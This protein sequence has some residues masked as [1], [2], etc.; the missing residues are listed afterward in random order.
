PP[1]APPPPPGPPHTHTPRLDSHINQRIS[2]LCSQIGVTKA[3]F[4]L[5]CLRFCLYRRSGGKDF[6]IGMPHA[7]RDSQDVTGLIG[8][9]VGTLVLQL[10]NPEDLPDESVANWLT[11]C[12]TKLHEVIANEEVSV[13]E[14]LAAVSPER[15]LDRSPLFQV[16]L[17]Y[18]PETMESFQLGDAC[19]R[20]LLPV[21]DQAK[22][23]WTVSVNEAQDGSANIA[24]EYAT[25][26]FEQATAE[27]VIEQLTGIAEAFA[28]SAEGPLARI[29][30]TPTRS[31]SCQ[32]FRAPPNR[33]KLMTSF[34]TPAFRPKS[35]GE[36]LDQQIREN[37]KQIAIE[38]GE[39]TWAYAELHQQTA[40]DIAEGLV[41]LSPDRSIESLIGCVA[42]L[43]HG[44]PFTFSHETLEADALPAEAACVLMTSGTTGQSK[45]VVISQDSLHRHSDAFANLM[46]LGPDDRVAQYASPEFDLFLEEVLPTLRSGATLCVVPEDCRLDPRRFARWLVDASISLADL[47]TAFFHRWME[48]LD[49]RKTLALPNL[50]RV[51]VGGE[52]LRLDAARKWL[53]CYPEIELWNTYGPT[54]ATIICSAHRVV[55]SD[56]SMDIPL[57]QSF[58]GAELFV[59]D[60]DGY[61][62]PDGVPG[63]LVIAGPGVALGYWTE[64]KL[65]RSGGF[66]SNH[67]FRTG[68]RVRRG[69]DGQLHF[70]GRVDEQVKI[71]GVRVSPSDVSRRIATHPSV[72]AASVVVDQR[73]PNP[74]L[75]A[76]LVLIDDAL[77]HSVWTEISSSLPPSMRP[78]RWVRCDRI[79]LTDRGKTDHAAIIALA[80]SAHPSE[81]ADNGATDW[82]GPVETTLA[83][84]WSN[85]LE[86][87]QFGRDDDFFLVGGHS[88][89]AALLS[90]EI[91]QAFEVELTLPQIFRRPTIA[92]LATLIHDACVSTT[93]NDGCSRQFPSHSPTPES[94][95][96]VLPGLPG[97]GELYGPLNDVLRQQSH[98]VSLSIPGL[99]E[100]AVPQSIPALAALWSTELTKRGRG[101]FTRPRTPAEQKPPVP[102]L[103]VDVVAHSFSASVLVEML[104]A[105]PEWASRCRRIVLLDAM[106]FDPQWLNRE[107]N[108]TQLDQQL[109]EKLSPLLSSPLSDAGPPLPFSVEVV[110]AD[111][112][113]EWMQPLAW[114]PHFQHVTVTH[115]EGDHRS[116]T[117]P[118][119]CLAWLEHSPP[120]Q[121]PA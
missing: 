60:A 64:G 113:R 67:S 38:S 13:D 83:Q 3:A 23:E 63:E 74:S 89:L 78:N 108:K 21:I 114:K 30:L 93:D 88:L 106:P 40:A 18:A 54:E 77:P 16:L 92:G 9:F 80:D 41:H 73:T 32:D 53:H 100:G 82:A 15:R 65:E 86:H 43:R 22:F 70:L 26:L 116:I 66:G 8:L 81:G 85:L 35:F 25:D 12:H 104:R 68:D 34:A 62:L 90:R 55:P 103:P 76:A 112:S 31:E 24:L 97:I 42:A 28:A 84:L 79:P 101:S 47:P 33:P 2:E 72:I 36:S 71:R 29:K 87:S 56:L 117:G 59:T 48:S 51:V 118:P 14:I 37:A 6:A 45:G 20:P 111:Q 1:P 69:F 96:V 19:L 10:E 94:I 91:S 110:V 44:R 99:F 75:V 52:K 5:A 11:R 120:P 4:W 119:H 115:C 57:G 121:R 27:Q 50:R 102:F 95:S 105:N 109:R 61:V 7:G 17:N 39:Q 58:A 46:K 107:G 49:D 98:V